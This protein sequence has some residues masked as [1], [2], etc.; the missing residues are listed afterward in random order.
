MKPK[1]KRGVSSKKNKNVELFVEK[2]QKKN[3]PPRSRCNRE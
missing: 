3:R 2:N 1:E